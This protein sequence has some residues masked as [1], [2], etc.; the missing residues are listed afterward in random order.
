MLLVLQAGRVILGRRPWFVSISVLRGW[1]QPLAL[2]P[3]E[4]TIFEPESNPW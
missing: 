1:H 3:I 2:W 4:P